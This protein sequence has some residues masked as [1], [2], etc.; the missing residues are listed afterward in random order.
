MATI[1]QRTVLRS[2]P[3]LVALFFALFVSP[4]AAVPPAGPDPALAA[5]APG[6]IRSGLVPAAESPAAEASATP[7]SVAPVGAG[8]N[9]CQPALA[10]VLRS[11]LD[12]GPAGSRAPPAATA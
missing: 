3:A 4:Q 2:L 1:T 7:A 11:Q 6:L 9:A 5:V 10:G 12:A 8:S